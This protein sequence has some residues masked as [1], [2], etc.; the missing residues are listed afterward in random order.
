MFSLFALV[1]P[2]LLTYSSKLISSNPGSL[3]LSPQIPHLELMYLQ[4]A[5]A[6]RLACPDRILS[7]H[8]YAK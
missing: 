5:T 6:M 8:L 1:I 7:V 4:V 3:C 2:M